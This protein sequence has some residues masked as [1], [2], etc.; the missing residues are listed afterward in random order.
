MFRPPIV[1]IFMEMFFEVYITQKVKII[2]IYK[3]TVMLS[4]CDKWGSCHHGMA[5]AQVADRGTACSMEGSCG[6][7]EEAVADR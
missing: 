5:R 2:V 6:Y 4:T 1:A 7:I 3:Q